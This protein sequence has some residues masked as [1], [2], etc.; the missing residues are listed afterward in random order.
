MDLLD[1]LAARRLATHALARG[2]RTDAAA[3]A[4]FA[5]YLAPGLRAVEAGTGFLAVQR[6]AAGVR[7]QVLAW[8][9]P[10]AW[11]GLP[12]W[13][14]TVDHA[15]GDAGAV[16]WTCDALDEMGCPPELELHLDAAFPEVRAH[17][18]DRGLG[19]DSVTQDGVPAEA[20][21]GLIAARNPPT[22]PPPGLDFVPLALAHVDA[23]VAL[24]GALFRAA[25]R[26]CSFGAEPAWLA[27][28][29]AGLRESLEAG[30][31]GCQEVALRDGEVV[32][33][34]GADFKQDPLWGWRSG[35]A[36]ML[37]P[38]LQ[39]QGLAWRI[40]RR[41]LEA[42]VAAGIEVFR[43]GTSQGPV[44][45]IGRALGRRPRSVW[46]RPRALTWF[47]PAWFDVALSAGASA[48][49]PATPAGGRSP[50]PG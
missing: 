31:A 27:R 30:E 39:G 45:A 46:L 36:V 28:F 12:S 47:E 20:L 15:P 50:G 8:P 40:Y 14:V 17:L 26:F 38:E 10:E 33:F 32:G 23:V 21:A 35:M 18:L 24:H 7:S 22:S 16:A 43:G 25:P 5:E 37:K 9:V 41:M 11:H 48:D 13:L 29:G 2:A 1:E 3:H 19:I 34:W 44:M 4:A 42:Q 49:T 6:D